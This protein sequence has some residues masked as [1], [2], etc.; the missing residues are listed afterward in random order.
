MEDET[1]SGG[2][3]T[4]SDNQAIEQ[5]QANWKRALASPRP[6]E[7]PLDELTNEDQSWLVNALSTLQ[8]IYEKRETGP[9]A[10][11]I[12]ALENSQAAVRPYVQFLAQ[13]DANEL[14]CE[15]VSAKSVPE[16]AAILGP[17]EDAALKN[18]GFKAPEKFNYWQL[19]PIAGV[20]DLAYA[21][22]LLYRTLKHVYKIA[23]I[24]DV[25]HRINLP[26]PSLAIPG[27][28]QVRKLYE[29]ALASGL[30]S[31]VHFEDLVNRFSLTDLE[32]LLEGGDRLKF[33]YLYSDGQGLPRGEELRPGSKQALQGCKLERHRKP[34]IHLI[35]SK[36]R[37][38]WEC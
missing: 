26:R 8:K 14:V 32:Y 22:R 38:N 5:E 28:R 36:K 2:T 24:I 15:A 4:P 37:S 29:I 9:D 1:T 19:I 20:A 35:R 3:P 10:F 13:W 7:P 12:F 27:L 31:A 34:A 16:I 17:E 23:N 11:C 18:L 30:G 25:K 21:A 6:G 33:T